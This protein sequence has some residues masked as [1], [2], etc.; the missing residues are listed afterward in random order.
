[1]PNL[2]VIFC[3][4]KNKLSAYRPSKSTVEFQ[5]LISISNNKFKIVIFTGFPIFECKFMQTTF[6]IGRFAYEPSFKCMCVY[7]ISLCSPCSLHISLSRYQCVNYRLDFERMTENLWKCIDLTLLR[8]QATNALLQGKWVSHSEYFSLFLFFI[9]I[10]SIFF[11]IHKTT[12]KLEFPIV[13]IVSYKLLDVRTLSGRRTV[14][15][16][17]YCQNIMFFCLSIHIQKIIPYNTTRSDI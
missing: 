12:Q 13:F 9:W 4:W 17:G 15:I 16:W 11:E 3:M 2:Y 7:W 8:I 5:I 1:M 10:E 6:N 14:N